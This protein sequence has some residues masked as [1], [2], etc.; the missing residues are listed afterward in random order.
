[1]RW[2]EGHV[3]VREAAGPELQI[4]AFGNCALPDAVRGGAV[5]VLVD[6][7]ERVVRNDRQGLVGLSKS[8]SASTRAENKVTHH[9]GHVVSEDK[10]ALHKCPHGKVRDWKTR[11]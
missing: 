8:Q 10:R 6:G 1:M 3:L 5:G 2:G 7:D 4:T 11:K 9:I